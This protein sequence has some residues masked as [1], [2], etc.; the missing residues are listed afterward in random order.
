MLN[1]SNFITIRLTILDG[2]RCGNREMRTFGVTINDWTK[3]K[4]AGGKVLIQNGIELFRV[5]DNGVICVLFIELDCHAFRPVP[6]EASFGFASVIIKHK[7]SVFLEARFSCVTVHI[8]TNGS[9][10]LL[11]FQCSGCRT[12]SG[13]NIEHSVNRSIVLISTAAGC[14]TGV[15]T[16]CCCGKSGDGEKVP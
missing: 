9:Y 7:N 8:V 11:E 2:C 13:F 1:S 15:I 3:T 5:Y 14:C 4:D 16:H 6:V 10:R 12:T